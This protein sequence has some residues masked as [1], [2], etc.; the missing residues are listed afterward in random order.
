MLAQ[1][2]A[3]G[4]VLGGRRRRVAADHRRAEAAQLAG[5][6]LAEQPR[7]PARQPFHEREDPRELRHRLVVGSERLIGAGGGEQRLDRVAGALGPLE[8]EGEGA[9]VAAAPLGRL[10]AQQVGDL[11][12][13]LAAD[14]AALGLVRRVAQEV[15][16]EADRAVARRV[17]EAGRDEVRELRLK[18]LGS[19]RRRAA[20][21]RPRRRARSSLRSG[22]ARGR[23]RAGRGGR[24][25]GRAVPPGS[26]WRQRSA[27]GR[28]R[29]A[30]AARSCARAPRGRAGCRR[31]GR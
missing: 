25:A 12:V 22:R 15:V 11:A 3:A 23:R 26:G 24:A 6:E 31:C 13:A 17:D 10:V 29:S 8:V 1:L 4:L 14:G 21:A 19:G 7:R 5:A 30:C 20:A 18:R 9:D 27:R 2:D 16:A 28:P